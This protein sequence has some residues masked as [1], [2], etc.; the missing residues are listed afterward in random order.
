MEV[1]IMRKLFVS[2]IYLSFIGFLFFGCDDDVSAPGSGQ[3]SMIIYLTDAPGNY[4]EVN[5]QIDRVEVHSDEQGWMIVSTF[6]VDEGEGRFNLLDLTNGV[7]EIIGEENLDAGWYNQVRLIL[8]D[9][10]SVV[11]T[12][13]S[14]H[15]L[16]VPSGEQTG[17]KIHHAFEIVEDRTYELLLDFDAHRSVHR[18]GASGLWILKPVI[19]AQAIEESGSIRGRVESAEEP[20]EGARVSVIKQVDDGEE[21]V[22]SS[23]TDENGDFAIVHI[24]PGDYIIQVEADGYQTK[25]LDDTVTVEIGVT[26]DLGVITIEPSE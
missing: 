10:N 18:A 7:M 13:G 26:K 21:V 8:T 11:L 23:P 17:L 9:N 16:K 4:E 2:I 14:E 6:D 15:S 12:D 25:R 24:A 20:V 5:I 3:G 19:R 22:T 1:A